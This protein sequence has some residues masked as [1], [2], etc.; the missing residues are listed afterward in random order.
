MI[1]DVLDQE[2]PMLAADAAVELDLLLNGVDVEAESVRLLAKKLRSM[3]PSENA[4]SAAHSLQTDTALQNVL[5]LAFA[6]I[7]D[8]PQTV[9]QNLLERTAETVAKLSNASQQVEQPVLKWQRA[10]C[11]ALSQ[12]AASHQQMLFDMRPT[13]PDRR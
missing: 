9:L 1:I 2:L 4:D 5:G 13:H 7:G 12:S 10:F 8:N 11:L 6:Q 3:L